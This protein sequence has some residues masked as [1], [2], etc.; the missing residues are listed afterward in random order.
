[1][2][3]VVLSDSANTKYGTSVKTVAIANGGTGYSVNDVLTLTGGDANCTCTVT[4]V[5]SGVVTA[6]SRTTVGSGYTASTQNT[7]VA[8][9]GGSG[10]T[11]TI[12]VQAG[13]WCPNGWYEVEAYNTGY[14]S[15]FTALT[16]NNA[17]IATP[18]FLH[19][20]NLQGVVLFILSYPGQN[21]L[22]QAAESWTLTLEENKSTFTVSIASPAIVT[23]AGH[24]FTGGE[25]VTLAT[26]GALPTGLTALTVT[27]YVRYIDANT[28]NLS[29]TPAGA[30]IN[31]SGTQSGTHTLW[32]DR[33]TKTLTH[34]DV[35]NQTGLV[36]GSATYMAGT[37]NVPFE[38]ATPY[39]VDTTVGKW[40]FLGKI[41]SALNRLTRFT[42]S[43][44]TALTYFAWGDNAVSFQDNDSIIVKDTIA[45]DGSATLKGIQGS[46]LTTM[47]WCGHVCSSMAGEGKKI[48]A[49]KLIWE[50]PPNAS[51][52]LT[53]DGR[54]G[55][56]SYGG[57][58]IGDPLNRIPIAQK[59]IIDADT[60]T[61]V[62]S[63]SC[64]G[65]SY[66]QTSNDNQ[67]VCLYMYGEIATNN[68]T[69]ANGTIANGASSF[70]TDDA[71][72]WVNG[73]KISVGK[74]AVQNADTTHY[75]VTSTSGTTVNISPVMST[76]RADNAKVVRLNNG[77][78]IK[79][80]GGT[81]APVQANFG[82]LIMSGVEYNGVG[83][84]CNGATMMSVNT[85]YQFALSSDWQEEQVLSDC[86]FYHPTSSTYF[87]HTFSFI[88]QAGLR[89]EDCI[90]HQGQFVGNPNWYVS[91]YFNSGYLK[92]IDNIM[93]NCNVG[94]TGLFG[95]SYATTTA[96]AKMY[97]T[98][99][100]LENGVQSFINLWGSRGTFSNNQFWGFSSTAA[101]SGHGAVNYATFINPV[102]ITGNTYDL[103]YCA[104]EI[105][106]Y[107]T[108]G[109]VDKNAV[110]GGT[111]ANTQDIKVLA[112]AYVDVEFLNPTG[113]SN[114]IDTERNLTI[115]GSHIRFNTY[116]GTTGD[117]RGYLTYGYFNSTGT[118]LTDTTVHT[119]GGYALR[120]QPTDSTNNLEWAFSVPTGNIQNNTMFVGV[121]CK[122][123]SATYYAGTNQLPRLT[124]TYDQT[125]TAYAQAAES[126]DWQLL[127]VPIT[128]LTTYGQITVTLSGRTDATTTNA[129]IYWD[130]FMIAY[131][132]NV[133][134]DLGAMDLWANALPITPPIA[135]PISAKTVSSA[136]WEELLTSH[137]TASTFGKHVGKKL[138]K[139]G[140]FIGLK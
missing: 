72:G 126:T 58:A 68:K 130:D 120:F 125:S 26:T 83:M 67:K 137:V 57:M 73:D 42:G 63:T 71:T 18:T 40:R 52:T 138:L 65:N 96:T 82:N 44:A 4:A 119:A 38:F 55:L 89:I 36:E 70:V 16:V 129:Y 102:E 136:V 25:T 113:I 100:V 111:S 99:N 139:T 104:V 3:K 47:A 39:A 133:A 34:A 123:N 124:I 105:L 21:P 85:Y 35:F 106:G 37:Y 51:Y 131:P 17:V 127:V 64:I 74:K 101:L 29:L 11:I 77:Y 115:L 30:L 79:I 33:A 31:T 88:P 66:S 6:I 20:C 117:N 46:G 23:L 92:L 49:C 103:C 14:N 109:V 108:A 32:A 110:F 12:T 135:V 98:G 112:G 50:N 53:L 87:T 56:P 5:S 94:A 122:I 7:T 27:Y 121:W 91:T 19:N 140:T 76:A 48:D 69:Q 28:F 134:L 45:I 116:N 118:G 80:Q 61:V 1:M 78:G 75:T 93:L 62:A 84:L 128:P 22:Y 10:C 24:G 60:A 95:I 132:P 41:S 43:T 8:P 2:A 86:S 15:E 90:L 97:I 114:V 59:A 107:P 13:L 54:L 9:A 81:W